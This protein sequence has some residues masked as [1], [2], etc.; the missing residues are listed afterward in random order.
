MSNDKNFNHEQ[1][2]AIERLIQWEEDHP[3]PDSILAI[4][5]LRFI[6]CQQQRQIEMLASIL[7]KIAPEEYYS[8]ALCEIQ[9]LPDIPN[10]PN[11]TTNLE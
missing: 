8:S 2:V 1:S 3:A 11:S 4:E 10:E 7:I 6:C 5:W 9:G